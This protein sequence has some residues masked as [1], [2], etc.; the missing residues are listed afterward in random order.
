MGLSA[1]Q[2]SVLL[3]LVIGLAVSV[4]F[5]LYPLFQPPMVI[6]VA[7]SKQIGQ[8][9]RN[10]PVTW[11]TVSLTLVTEDEK[12]DI[13]IGRT[14]AYIIEKEVFDRLQ[15]GD[16]VRGRLDGRELDVVE[17]THSADFAT[18]DPRFD[19]DSTDAE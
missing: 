16:V 13:P 4:G 8:G 9:E 12:N 7:E 5:N 3:V 11:Y 18:G 15:D 19:R 1:K 10:G 6:G 17:L 14:M 2:V